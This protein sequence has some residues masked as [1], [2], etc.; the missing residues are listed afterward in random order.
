MPIR[1]HKM[2]GAGNDFVLLDLR[3][4]RFDLERAQVCAIAD[5]HTGVGFDQMLVLR[6]PTGKD[7]LV[8]IELF[9]ADGSRAEQCGNGMRCIGL[10]LHMRGETAGGTFTVQAP[11]A[12]IHMTCLPDGQVRVDMGVPDF[13]PGR[14]PCQAPL[15]EN[16]F[17]RLTTDTDPLVVGAVSMGNPH[18]VLEVARAASA[19]VARL[20]PL[21]SQ[22]PAFPEGCNTGFA[23]VIDR[24]TI[25]LRVFER[26]AG[27]TRACGSGSCA[28]TAILRRAGRLER[29]V[30]VIQEGGTLIVE[31][32]GDGESLHMTGPA[33]HVFEG[34]LT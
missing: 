12:R 14:V 33:S 29:R 19:D 9:N 1:F 7:C 6:Q 32:P 5:R 34:T 24:E 17:Y 13:T 25:R 28:A 23:E 22:H 2:H 26:G 4:Q 31:W 27:E 21:I 3:E 20:G 8:D 15:D 18:A 30:A 11:V 10:Y 16:G